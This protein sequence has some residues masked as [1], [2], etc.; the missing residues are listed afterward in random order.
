[1]S[2]SMSWL[3]RVY[4]MRRPIYF[5]LIILCVIPLVF[6]IK[7]P[8]GISPE[9]RAVYNVIEKLPADSVVALDIGVD[10]AMWSDMEPAVVAALEH[11]VVRKSIKLVAVS[12]YPDGPILI[13]RAFAAV[14]MK[15]KKYG[16]DYVNLGYLVGGETAIAAFAKDIRA[17][18]RSDF[19]G[20]S[21]SDLPIMKAVNNAKDFSLYIYVIQADPATQIRQ[22]SVP[23]GVRM[24]GL[25]TAFARPYC[26][27]YLLAGQISGIVTGLRGGAEYEYLVGLY[28]FGLQSTTTMSIVY[29]ATVLMVILGNVL[30]VWLRR[31]K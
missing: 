3:E 24:I 7:T 26:M 30:Y 5:L 23:Y 1:M 19:R 2:S 25:T 16:V 6:P 15:N 14:D 21:I 27:P 11:I 20:T 12:F 9:T 10:V 29:I 4:N 22:I 31:K 8:V 28:R 13:E 18:L 17:V